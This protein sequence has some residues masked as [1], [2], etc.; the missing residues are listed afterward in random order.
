MKCQD[1]CNAVINGVGSEV[2]SGSE[3]LALAEKLL[4]VPRKQ[5][6]TEGETGTQKLLV[7]RKVLA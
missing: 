4:H 6:D 3:V 2:S 7:P 1:L 5:D